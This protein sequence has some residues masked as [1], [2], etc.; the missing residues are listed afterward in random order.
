MGVNTDQ[1]IRFFKIDDKI[2]NGKK[3]TIKQL[4]TAWN[5]SCIDEKDK[6]TERTIAT[7]IKAIQK[8]FE[9]AEID[10]QID[11]KYYSYSDHKFS[12][13]QLNLN[14]NDE[15]F[16]SFLRMTLQNFENTDI[17]NK[18]NKL[19]NKVLQE[20][21]S[22]QTT[23]NSFKSFI[24]PEISF[25]KSGYEWIETLFEA[26]N[27]QETIE[28]VYRK[29]SK[30]ISNKTLSPYLLKE[31]RKRW[32]LIAYD[33]AEDRKCTKVY[34]LDKIREII[35]SE[36]KFYID[37]FF[38]PNDYFKYTFGIH[39]ELFNKPLDI[40]LEFYGTQVDQLMNH[41]LMASQK[42]TIIQGGKGLRV[43]LQVYNSYEIKREILGYGK[44]VKVISPESL[45][46]DIKEMAQEIIDQYK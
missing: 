43:E 2:K 23:T 38:N 28:I 21:K 26:I 20:N 16:F 30:E 10:E 22:K 40:V 29:N 25:G 46:K 44:G 36:K 33:H 24:L 18:F 42:S 7:D 4:A 34:A 9:G 3:A 32:Y 37:T 19:R 31:F 17:Y 13:R 1:L 12:I 8:V 15:V 45:V 11:G 5:N 35:E 6:V 39:H 41:P 14:E 27:K